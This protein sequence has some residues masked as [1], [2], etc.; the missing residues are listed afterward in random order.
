[1][2]GFIARRS[3]GGDSTGEQ[4]HI[5]IDDSITMTIG[6]ATAINTTGALDLADA[7][8]RVLGIV[9]GFV[10]QNGLPLV[11]QHATGTDYTE[12]GRPGVPG[13]ETV[14]TASDNTTDSQVQAVVNVD[15]KQE[16]YN[17]ADDDLDLT[18]D[19]QYFDVVAAADQID[20][21][22]VGTTG[23][24]ICVERDPDSDSDASKGIFRIAE[25][26]LYLG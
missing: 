19:Y 8:E 5:L 24:F 7:G 26:A 11:A 25:S 9:E 21:G 23:Q 17:D 6:D 22:T 3:E 2:A 4:R 20:A 16:Y 10:D 12:S 14:V 18:D 1:M 15:P 13:S